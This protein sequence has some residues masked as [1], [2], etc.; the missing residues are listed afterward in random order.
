MRAAL[1]ALAL[2]GLV[3][4]PGASAKEGV[5]AEL[6]S[7]LP[8]DAQS[9]TTIDV[10]WSLSSPSGPFGAM[11]VYVH[12]IGTGG[13]STEA[14][15]VGTSHPDGRYSASVRVP[16]GGIHGIRIG[17]KGT[18]EIFFPV[19][20]NPFT[21]RRP[22]HLPA[23]ARG[24]LCPVSQPD[25]AVDFS[26][27]GV[28]RGIGD[29]PAYPVGMASGALTFAPAANFGSRAWGGQKVLWVVL[30]SYLGPVLIRGAR[31]D[32]SGDVRFD[33]GNVPPKELLIPRA[34]ADSRQRASY[35]RLKA[36]GCYAYQIDGTT[37]SKVV[38][39][40]AASG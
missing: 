39:F 7:T 24:A 30:P 16:S 8:L 17:L 2:L 22:L 37:F 13:V 25:P 29:G 1:L 15:S 20:N 5:L 27:Y 38:V 21:L 18:T 14:A 12:L 36:P 33:L 11:N 23:L 32:G 34:T 3:L 10:S 9:G 6:T 35:T 31:L 26:L 19:V 40:R 28:A 4:V